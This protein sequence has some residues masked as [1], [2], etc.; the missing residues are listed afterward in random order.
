[1][2][3]FYNWSGGV[4]FWIGVALCFAFP[5]GTIVGIILIFYSLSLGKEAE[6]I[7]EKEN[8]VKREKNS[9]TFNKTYSEMYEEEMQLRKDFKLGLK[10]DPLSKETEQIFLN[11]DL[12]SDDIY[13]AFKVDDDYDEC[14]LIHLDA[15]EKYYEDNVIHFYDYS[16]KN[17]NWNNDYKLQVVYLLFNKIKHYKE[18]CEFLGRDCIPELLEDWEKENKRQKQIAIKTENEIKEKKELEKEQINYIETILSQKEIL[19]MERENIIEH[20]RQEFNKKYGFFVQLKRIRGVWSVTINGKVK[21][22]KSL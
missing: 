11:F 16:N 14:I 6:E 20:A 18:I 5:I 10:N 22:L 1:M 2:K 15:F 4:V 21:R 7:Q 19:K 12:E 13:N 3:W 17:F 9:A 8:R